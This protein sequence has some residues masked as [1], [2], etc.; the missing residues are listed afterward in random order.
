MLIP[1]T[2]T[3]DERAN[4]LLSESLTP[5]QIA[6][7]NRY[8]CFDV[9]GNVTKRR[10]RIFWGS[11]LNVIGHDGYSEKAYCAFIPDPWQYLPNGDTMLAEKLSIEHDEKRF[12]KTANTFDY[13]QVHCSY[14]LKDDGRSFGTTSYTW[15]DPSGFVLNKLVGPPACPWWHFWSLAVIAVIL[16]TIGTIGLLL[17]FGLHGKGTPVLIAR[18]V[19]SGL[20]GFAVGMA[21]SARLRRHWW[22]QRAGRYG[23]I[24]A[25]T[26]YHLVLDWIVTVIAV[27]GMLTNLILVFM[28]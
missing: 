27:I 1:D 9:V 20:W 26:R 19:V 12:L 10:Y 28:A 17:L 11:H 8:Y 25:P 13:F 21:L 24:L 23:T 16:G 14:V 22:T 3:P 4:R 7:F 5:Q 2:L 15:P 18:P 6:M